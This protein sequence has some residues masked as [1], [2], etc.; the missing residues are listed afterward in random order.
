MSS[1]Q[2]FMNP[3]NESMLD[4]LVYQD[5]HRRLGSDLN[6]KQKSRL[7]KTVHHYMEEVSEKSGSMNIQEMNKQVLTLVVPDFNAYLNRQNIG[8]KSDLD[9]RMK[10]D[11]SSRYNSIQNERSDDSARALMPPTPDFR[12]PLDDDNTSPLSLFE[13]AKKSRESEV[14]QTSSTALTKIVEPTHT[15][16]VEFSGTYLKDLIPS[17]HSGS[18]SG[19]ASANPTIAKIDDLHSKSVLPQDIIIPQDDILT[20]KENEYNLVIYSADRDWYNNQRENRYNF[21]VSFNPA[22]NGQGFKYSPSANMRFHNIVRIEMVKALLPAEAIDTILTNNSTAGTISTKPY[23]ETVL[24]L[25]GIAL[26][27]DELESNVFGTDDTLDRA[28]ATLQYDAQWLGSSSSALTFPTNVASVPNSG[29]YAMIPKFL[30]CQRIYY[31]TPLATLTKMSIQLQRPNGNLLN[32]ALDT[33]NIQRIFA[34]NSLPIGVSAGSSK[35]AGVTDST[36]S[37]YYFIQTSTF[38]NAFNFVSG[39]LINIQGINTNLISGNGTAS[40]DWANYLQSSSGLTIIQT[41]YLASGTTIT[42]SPNNA[43]Y[44]NLIVLQNRFLDPTT[45]SVGVNPFGGSSANN[46]FETVLS[47]VSSLTGAMLINM[48]KQVQLTFRVITRDMD[49]ATRIRPNN[50]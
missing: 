43:N 26:H 27:I 49:S 10:E 39:D 21:S 5:F 3:K 16:N 30:K 18:V 31:P 11:I 36:Y 42:D 20:Y 14:L 24:S 7:V 38:F 23:A 9:S 50:A 28:F 13:Q 25:P 12:I 44:C 35:Y 29:Y 4:K 40:S 47:S 1:S 37:A 32:T 46:N 6:D 34:S 41:G 22:N 15:S 33:L 19:S 8:I 45:G 48:S 17:S 2:T